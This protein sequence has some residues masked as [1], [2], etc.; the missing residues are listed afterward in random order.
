V[1]GC[2]FFGF[3]A[4]AGACNATTPL[5]PSMPHA[6]QRVP[7]SHR[8]P[9]LVRGQCGGRP[10]SSIWWDLL[11]FALT[12]SGV[13]AAHTADCIYIQWVLVREA[14]FEAS[15]REEA[16]SQAGCNWLWA[17]WLPRLCWTSL[18]PEGTLRVGAAA[19]RC[20]LQ[21]CAGSS[22]GLQLGAGKRARH[23]HPPPVLH[24]KLLLYPLCS[25]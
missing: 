14:C 16:S 25:S 6:P 11:Y 7:P 3:S 5:A 21:G 1:A 22:L 10:R 19:W 18:D 24:T 13:R 20:C 17:N 9:R 4:G 2:L 12:R 8:Q 23:T 15:F